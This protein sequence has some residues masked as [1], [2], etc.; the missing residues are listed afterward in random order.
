MGKMVSE[1]GRLCH[2]LIDNKF[3]TVGLMTSVLWRAL[4]T[5][6]P[7]YIALQTTLSIAGAC[8]LGAMAR[9][10]VGPHAM[11]PTALFAIVYLNFTTAVFGGFQLETVQAFF[12]IVAARSALIA[13]ESDNPADLFVAGLCAGCGAMFKPT[14][15]AVLGAA[16]IALLV[17]PSR[18]TPIHLL[19]AAFG[20]AIP[21]CVAFIYLAEA[22]L[23]RDMPA[24]YRQISTYAQQTAWAA[25]DVTK[26]LVAAVFIGFPMLIRGWIARRQRE[27]GIDWPQRQ[28]MIFAIAWFIAEMLGVVMQRRMYAY[29]FLP[30]VPPAALLFGMIPRAARPITLAQA[31][32]PMVLLSVYSAGDVVAITYSGE[33]QLPATRYLA[34]QAKPNDAVWIDCWPR[35]ALETNLRPGARLPFTFLFANYDDAGLDYAAGIIDDFER[36]KPAYVFLPV[37]LDKRVQYQLDFV[38]ELMRRPVRRQNYAE[39]WHRIAA[40][41]QA[42]YTRQAMVGAE[43]VY[44]RNPDPSSLTTEARAQ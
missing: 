40:Y 1:G 43:A 13:F 41:V 16:G 20:V 3:P 36:I 26:P 32:V 5:T 23:L 14:G 18:K 29:H 15:L 42:H 24:L 37:P 11:W 8:M 31:L 7:A 25:E 39:G 2:D 28:V 30:I 33:G 27:P 21:L 22:D 44:R 9:R 38:A 4:G 10:H 34:A 6:W 12:A 17:R 35:L 19:A